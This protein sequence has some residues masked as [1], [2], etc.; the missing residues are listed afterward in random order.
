MLEEL[1][2]V[3]L[4]RGAQEAEAFYSEVEEAP[5]LFEANRLKQL[6]GRQVSGV[7]L[8]VIVDGRLGAASSSRPGDVEGLV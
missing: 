2:D 1:I 6:N 8:R 7:A 5:V 4:R 3:A